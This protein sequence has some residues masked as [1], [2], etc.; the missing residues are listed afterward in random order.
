MRVLALLTPTHPIQFDILKMHSGFISPHVSLC[1]IML[2]KK[3]STGCLFSYMNTF[4]LWSF[5]GGTAV[6]WWLYVD[7]RNALNNNTLS[8]FGKEV[9][10][11]NVK[12]LLVYA[13][14]A[15]I[16]TVCLNAQVLY[17]C[18]HFVVEHM[19][20]LSLESNSCF[21]MI[22]LTKY[23]KYTNSVLK[24]SI[25]SLISVSPSR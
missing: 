6:L 18:M 15:T 14:G 1:Y 3:N 11:D 5:A 19:L 10:S 20:Y 4:L 7:H 12:A 8:V 9:A 16:F 24:N 21:F 13:I 22:Y 17:V 2:I 23:I 25:R